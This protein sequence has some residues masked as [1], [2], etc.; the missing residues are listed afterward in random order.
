M[1]I[2]ITI[3]QFKE[4]FILKNIEIPENVLNYMIKCLFNVSGS[5]LSLDKYKIFEIFPIGSTK[6]IDLNNTS[7][8]FFNE[9]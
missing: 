3:T 1:G 6:D 5:L 8:S 7:E 4:A 9:N 2:N